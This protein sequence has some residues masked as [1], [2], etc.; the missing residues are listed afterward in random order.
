M[1]LLTR[2]LINAFALFLATRFI[3]GVEVK[4]FYSALWVALVLGLLNAVARPVLIFLTLPITAVTLGLFIFVINALIIW[5]TSSI[6]KGFE[7][8]GFAPAFI[9]GLF[10]WLVS[11]LTNALLFDRN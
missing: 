1:Y 5:F 9:L 6:I 2:W 4:S 7:V 11:T 8:T 10:L 3:P